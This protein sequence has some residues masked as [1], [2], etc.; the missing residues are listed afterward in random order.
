MNTGGSHLG[1]WGRA[2]CLQ[3]EPRESPPQGS[4]ATGL[5]PTLQPQGT[6]PGSPEV[7]GISI[8]PVPMLRAWCRSHPAALRTPGTVP[9]LWP[10]PARPW[11]WARPIGCGLQGF[12]HLPRA[13]GPSRGSKQSL[14]FSRLL[15]GCGQWLWG[16]GPEGLWPPRPPCGFPD[17]SHPPATPT[18]SPGSL[19]RREGRNQQALGC[20][21]LF[22]FIQVPLKRS[23]YKSAHEDAQETSPGLHSQ[24]RML[25]LANVHIYREPPEKKRGRRK[26]QAW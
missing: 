25:R 8:I 1:P 11:P 23:L 6:D 3:A 13:L 10:G 12:F 5:V 19:L 15:S 7:A 26:S 16:Q 21:V 14:S 24:R 22:H 2:P 9:S 4:S 18:G 20:G 17:Q